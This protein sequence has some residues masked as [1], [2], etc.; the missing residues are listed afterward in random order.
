MVWPK[1]YEMVSYI[2]EAVSLFFGGIGSCSYLCLEFKRR[3]AMGKKVRIS[4][5]SINCYG[6]RILTGG[7][8]YAQYA[9]NPVLLYMHDRGNGVVGLVKNLEV[10]DGA[11]LGELEF[12]CA[13]ELSQR[14]KKQYEFGSM[15][16]V[17]G[18]FQILETSDKK[19][20]VLDGQT[21][22]TVTRCRLFEVSAVD[23]G[24]ND[25]A[26]VLSSPDGE[27]L[28]TKS[29]EG[30]AK[31]SLVLPLLNNTSINNPLKKVTQMETKQL[32]LTLGLADTATEAEVSAKISELKL[33]GAKAVHLETQ[34]KDLEAKLDQL[35]LADITT[36]VETAIKEKRISAD[37][38]AH[39]IELGKKVGAADL[40][41]LLGQMQ[42]QMKLRQALHL[43]SQNVV[44]TET[45]DFAKYEKLSAVPGQLMDDLI[46]NHQG[47]YIRL[48]NAEY[49]YGPIRN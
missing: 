13:T 43:T 2:Y 38:K 12:D 20:L 48:F 30:R 26:I 7:I 15:R 6:T 33:A 27:T 40:K 31:H 41:D 36:A 21:T 45:G 24:G 18:N 37:K 44:A 5:E 3:Y 29:E 16:M 22:Q 28:E 11:L 8:D 9:K 49:G 35:Q 46:D 1:K 39:F 4:D 23:I 17:S 10:K 19:D 25:N 14:L 32:A 34:V 42:P 47:E